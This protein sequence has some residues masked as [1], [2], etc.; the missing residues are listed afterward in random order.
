MALNGSALLHGAFCTLEDVCTAFPQF[1]RQQ[2]GSVSDDDI[3]GWIDDKKSRIRAT[4]LSR[5]YDTDA[6]VLN[7]DQKRFLRALNRDG[8]IPDLGDALQGTLTL[9]PGEYSLPAMRRK[10]YET[11]LKEILAGVYDRLFNP[12]AKIADV[13]SQMKAVGG[14]ETDGSTP[15]DRGENRRFGVNQIF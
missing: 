5:G 1:Q 8:A 14:A 7:D 4:L 10:T 6:L 3:Q 9:Q 15:A 13:A 12:T 2:P 11:V